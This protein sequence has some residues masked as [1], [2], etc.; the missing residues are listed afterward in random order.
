[1]ANEKKS[2]G[3]NRKQFVR[4]RISLGERISSV[5]IF[6]LLAGIGVAIDIKGKHF[7]PNLFAVRTESL[8]ST[9]A[10]VEGK[11]GTASSRPFVPSR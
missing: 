4:S 5:V 7:D 1:M 2:G 8:N 6:V 3:G 11:A 10:A 9:K